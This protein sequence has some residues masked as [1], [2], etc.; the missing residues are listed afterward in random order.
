VV[1]L[2][3]ELLEVI[4][5]WEESHYK[6]TQLPPSFAMIS[7]NPLLKIKPMA[8]S[9]YRKWERGSKTSKIWQGTL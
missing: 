3:T 1:L 7:T 9:L 2:P 8:L 6:Q 5:A 4:Q